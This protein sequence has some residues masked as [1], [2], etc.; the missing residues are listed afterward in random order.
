VVER[1][2]SL[3]FPKV[4]G[5]STRDFWDGHDILKE[6]VPGK[7]RGPREWS[8]DASRPT[9]G[10]KGRAMNGYGRESRAGSAHHQPVTGRTGKQADRQAGRLSGMLP[11]GGS[12]SGSSPDGCLTSPCIRIS[13]ADRLPRRYAAGHLCRQADMQTVIRVGRQTATMAGRPKE[14]SDA[15]P[16]HSGCGNP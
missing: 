15:A 14:C 12:S 5:P 13:H 8:S 2:E 16:Q 4:S 1:L 6:G 7:G 10:G 11:I 9:H 3:G